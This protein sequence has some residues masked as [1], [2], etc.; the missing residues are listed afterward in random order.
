MFPFI[1]NTTDLSAINEKSVTRPSASAD[2][3]GN[4]FP[5]FRG[6]LP[7]LGGALVAGAVAIT[8]VNLLG[9]H[10]HAH[11]RLQAVWLGPAIL[12]FGALELLQA[13]LWHRL[14]RALG[15]HLDAPD[16]LA[17]WCVSAV[18]R[19]VPTSMLMPVVR[20]RMS[21]R[22]QV[23][24]DVCLASVVYEAVL[25]TCGA[26]CMAAYFVITLPQ[27]HGDPWR[28]AI[29]T[30]PLG[31]TAVLHPRLLA[32]LSSRVLARAGR[33]PL[34]AHLSQRQL[35]NF[36]AGYA[37]S[38]IVAG[39]GLAA[40]VLMLHTVSLQILPTITG[41]MAIGFIASTL[42]FVLPGGLGARE[43][44]LV[45]ALAPVLP[46]AVATGAAVLVRLVQIGVEVILALALPWIV[47]RRAARQAT[48]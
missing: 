4:G 33:P 26:A 37:M 38:F 16:A 19:Y 47:R 8:V 17:I 35:L 41:A 39:S 25:V 43:A 7:I 1:T 24:G 27:F 12:A 30:I 10:P 22:R 2:R 13:E 21:R 32:P 28:W 42:A 23:L 9:D 36:T 15:G 34:P 6:L 18:A 29:V 40:V 46:T 31:A 48:G 14:L 45:I 20:V 11:L 44:A 3:R 5:G